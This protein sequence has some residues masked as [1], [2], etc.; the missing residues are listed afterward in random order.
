MLILQSEE[1]HG[2]SHSF[3]IYLSTVQLYGMPPLHYQLRTITWYEITFIGT[4]RLVSGPAAL[5]P[6]PYGF[7]VLTRGLRFG[8]KPRKPRYGFTVPNPALHLL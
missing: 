5:A 6:N 3:Q 2:K 1:I 7:V 4:H 8:V